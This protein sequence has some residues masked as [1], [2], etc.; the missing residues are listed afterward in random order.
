MSEYAKFR[1]KLMMAMKKSVKS[2][3]VARKSKRKS[4]KKIQSCKY[5]RNPVTGKCNSKPSRK[6]SRKAS[7]KKSATRK[8]SRKS[9]GKRALNAYMV[10]KEKARKGNKQSFMYNGNKYEKSPDSIG[11]MVFYIKVG[12]KKS[13]K[14]SRKVS[15]KKSRKVS[16]KK[17]RKVSRKKSRKASGK[18]GMNTFM[19][20]KEKARN[21]NKK[22]F[23]YNGNKY[24]QS[25]DSA[26]IYKRVGGKAS[27]KKSRKA[28]NT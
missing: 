4:R 15:R 11:A 9:N 26:V 12:G 17:S 13:R 3:N 24:V 16:R 1:M 14:K 23:V 18:R 19:V 28:S 2:R 5:G 10:V 6:K 21:A 20:A 27:R 25:K 8:K 7:R 22:S